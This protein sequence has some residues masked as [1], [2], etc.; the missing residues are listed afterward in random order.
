MKKVSIIVPMYQSE[1]TISD[2]INSLLK[3]TYKNIEIIIVD[4]GS[5][6]S[7]NKIAKE[8]E[9]KYNNV[10]VIKKENGGLSSARNFGIKNSN[11]EYIGFCDADDIWYEDK[12]EQHILA[13]G[14]DLNLDVSFSGCKIINE[15]GK[16]LGYEQ[17]PDEKYLDLKE[18]L[19]HNPIG[20]GSS[21][22]IK[23]DSLNK[24]KKDGAWF[25]EKLKR[26]ED[27]DLWSRLLLNN[28]KIKGISKA[29]VGY[30]VLENG[31][32]SNGEEQIKSWI[33]VKDKIIKN[34]PGTIEKFC[35]MAESYQLRWQTRK[36]VYA[37]QRGKAFYWCC[38]ML[39]KN[40]FIIFDDPKKTLETI[41]GVVVCLISPKMVNIL[42]KKH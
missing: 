24:V 11:G 17:I 35:D 30:R 34:Y 40:I 23:R 3:Q 27:I 37:G 12:V 21:V 14:K 7:G 26:S 16:C 38:K 2:T 18:L 39:K 28:L 6:D 5:F 41:A 10:K 36:S 19:I 42:L 31:L 25:D 9:Y 1:K 29:L 32:S 33:Y 13:F 8:Y 22:I 4:D 15:N 20:N